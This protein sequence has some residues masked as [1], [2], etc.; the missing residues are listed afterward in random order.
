MGSA[1]AAGLRRRHPDVALAVME[2]DEG[3]AT[4]AQEE[5]GAKRITEPGELFAAADIVVLAIKP[6]ILLEVALQLQPHSDGKK[7]ISILAGTSIDTLENA[8]ATDQIV[9]FMPNIAAVEQKALVGVAYGKAVDPKFVKQAKSIAEGMGSF[10]VV[11]EKLLAGVTGLS[12]SGIAFVFAFMHAMALGG[13]KAGIAYGDSLKIA[14]DTIDGALAL[15]RS[16]G[17]NPVELITKITSPGGTTIEGVAALEQGR[18][19]ATVMDAVVAAAR[20]AESLENK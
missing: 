3:R 9:R 8:L 2:T 15:A 17:T 18:F 14:I 19:T 10:I 4:R 5:L 6:Q 13:T 20:R 7:I 12:G 16:S 11:P 1:L